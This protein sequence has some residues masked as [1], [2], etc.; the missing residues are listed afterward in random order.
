MNGAWWSEHAAETLVKYLELGSSSGSD[1][2]NIS[3][4]DS[5]EEGKGDNV[6]LKG[7]L[8]MERGTPVQLGGFSAS[9]LNATKSATTGMCHFISSLLLPG[10]EVVYVSDLLSSG[11]HR[12]VC[13][14][15]LK[16]GKKNLE[17]QFF[18]EKVALKFL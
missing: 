12:V 3:V 5:E 14:A 6:V 13:S 11:M 15:I 8:A 10:A 16:T 2:S 18:F 17:I 1:S 9:R 4:C 7:A